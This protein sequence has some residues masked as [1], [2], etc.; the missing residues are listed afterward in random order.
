M[1]EDLP[2]RFGFLCLDRV[3][4]PETPTPVRGWALQRV[5]VYDL[6]TH[7]EAGVQTATT[8]NG[9]QAVVIGD[10]FVS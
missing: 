9:D 5:G 4:L 1:H 7:P 6:Y 8:S 10:V 3:A 2:Y